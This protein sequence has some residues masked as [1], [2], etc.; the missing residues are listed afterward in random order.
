PGLKRLEPELLQEAEAFGVPGSRKTVR[1]QVDAPAVYEE[2]LLELREKDHAAHGRLCRGDEEAVI[3][4][5]VLARDGRHRV[6]AEAVR[7]EPLARV[8][9][10]WPGAVPRSRQHRRLLLG[11]WPFRR[12]AARPPASRARRP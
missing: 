10:A 4:A 3:P 9:L 6:P 12:G 7:L 8:G 2:R 1:G 5:R 11:P